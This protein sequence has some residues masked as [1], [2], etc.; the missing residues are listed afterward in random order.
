MYF[1]HKGDLLPLVKVDMGVMAVKEYSTLLMSPE[2]ELHYQMQ[3]SVIP[4]LLFFVGS[5]TSLQG[6]QPAFIRPADEA[7]G[8]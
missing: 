3:F 6:I 4:R 5:L 2:L 8:E 7:Y 1:S